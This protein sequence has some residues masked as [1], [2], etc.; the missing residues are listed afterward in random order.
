MVENRGQEFNKGS[1]AD[2][3]NKVGV[4]GSPLRWRF[5]AVSAEWTGHYYTPETKLLQAHIMHC[6]WSDWSP[7]CKK[8]VHEQ[9]TRSLLPIV[10]L[11]LMELRFQLVRNPRYSP[12]FIHSDK[13]RNECMFCGIGSI[14]LFE[15]DLFTEAAL[16]QL[17]RLRWRIKMVYAEK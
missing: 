11:K 5:V 6:Y 14:L 15:Y 7:S 2:K 12:D 13:D 9:P 1:N 4:I 17:R 8:N 16:E 3:K 10:I